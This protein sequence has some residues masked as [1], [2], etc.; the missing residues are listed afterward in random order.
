MS[1]DIRE[2]IM[3]PEEI[4]QVKLALAALNK[5]RRSADENTSDGTIFDGKT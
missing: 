3:S 5:V 2:R 1:D 4:R